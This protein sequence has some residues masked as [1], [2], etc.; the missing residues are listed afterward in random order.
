MNQ[1]PYSLELLDDLT[2]GNEPSGGRVD[3]VPGSTIWGAIARNYMARHGLGRDDAHRDDEFRRLFL[4]A[5]LRFLNAYP[6]SP[7]DESR[8]LLPVPA[9]ISRVKGDPTGAV[10]R[11]NV[12][13]IDGMGITPI[14]GGFSEA[15]GDQLVCHSTAVRHQYHTSRASR[16]LGRAVE[17]GGPFAYQVLARGQRFRGLILGTAQDLLQIRKDLEGLRLGRSKSAQYGCVRII[18]EDVGEFTSEAPRED[19][20]IGA[21]AMIVT[22]TSHLIPG[23]P[24]SS[25]PTEFPFADFARL[26]AADERKLRDSCESFTRGTVVGG[27]SSVWSLPREQAFAIAAGSVFIFRSVDSSSLPP[28]IESHSLG[29]RTAEGFGRFVVNWPQTQIHRI[30]ESSRNSARRPAGDPP[31]ELLRIAEK[32]LQAKIMEYAVGAALTKCDEILTKGEG[33]V[34]PSS[35]SLNR[36]R[37]ILESGQSDFRSYLLQLA[38]SKDRQFAKTLRRLRINDHMDEFANSKLDEQKSFGELQKLF[39]E[40]GLT[41]P[42]ID[43]AAV[44]AFGLALV[45]DLSRRRRTQTPTEKRGKGG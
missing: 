44:R 10:D 9:T 15:I 33:K 11:A 1:L 14:R 22:L 2:F 20:V 41:L 43:D 24:A 17:G 30:G 38:Q 40:L 36:I 19:D 27:F 7:D 12:Q 8:R 26:L 32:V 4:R 34:I 35:S 31:K 3:Y 5:D 18:P 39:E 21:G 28:D 13:S 23:A 6:V 16:A 29:R 37:A 25:A 45:A 42:S